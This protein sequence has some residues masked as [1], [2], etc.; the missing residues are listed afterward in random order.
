MTSL[1]VDDDDASTNLSPGRG[2]TGREAYVSGDGAR[3]RRRAGEHVRISTGG[4]PGADACVAVAGRRSCSC[5]VRASGAS[6]QDAHVTH[7]SL[8]RAR[9]EAADATDLGAGVRVG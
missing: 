3:V 7:R 1:G 5:R 4:R 8:D 2:S 6:S 9:R